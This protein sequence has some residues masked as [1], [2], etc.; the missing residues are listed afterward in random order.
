MRRRGILAACLHTGLFLAAG[1]PAGAQPWAH[2]RDPYIEHL[3]APPAPPPPAWQHLQLGPA[4]QRYRFPVYASQQLDKPAALAGIRRVVIALHGARRDARQAYDAVTAL[5]GRN[6]D[7]ADDTLVMAPRY[8]TPVEAGFAG[9]P[10]WRR[11]GWADGEPSMAASGRPPPVGAY[12]VLDD[13]LREL[14]LSGRMPLLRDVVLAGHGAGGQMV[15][16]YAVLN[17]L[18]EA[19]RARGV[20]TT[21]VVANA[22]SYLYLGQQRPRSDGRGFARYERG[23]CPTYNRYPYGL[24]QLPPDLAPARQD[25]LAERYGRRQVVYLLGS[26]DNNP[27]QRGLDK[28]CGAEAQGA[29]R[30][31]RGTEYWRHEAHRRGGGAP[32][33]HQAHVV[34]DVGHAV[35]AM[36]GS[37]CGAP[38]LLGPGAVAAADGA[39]CETPLP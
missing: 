10:A 34:Q 35:A 22:D 17:P 31:A 7:R 37:E 19:L 24:D 15:Q 14:A 32:P 33:A 27:E 13:L 36:Y 28:S 1:F 25:Q 11:G 30:L 23:I 3:P 4:Q 21:Y 9:M 12:Q 38:A 2:D 20:A 5:Y 39:A 29:T 16:R 8:P 18:D 26:A 6:R